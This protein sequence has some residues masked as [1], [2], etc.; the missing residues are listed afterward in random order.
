MYWTLFI[1][2]VLVSAP[3]AAQAAEAKDDTLTM[4]KLTFTAPH[5]EEA[6]IDLG[7]SGPSQGDLFIFSGPLND[8]E[9]TTQGRLD[10][11][12]V[13]ISAPDKNDRERDRRQCFVTA[14]MGAENGETEIQAA[15][16]GR[17]L[18]EDVL[19][20]VTGG[21]NRFRTVRGQALFDYRTP[22]QIMISYDLMLDP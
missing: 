11:H 19:L 16:V 20:S 5:T 10:G 9:G 1:I 6:H 17:I 8:A 4:V 13:M 18:A 7:L 21:T 3:V 2:G 12:C 22:D 14:T 15:G